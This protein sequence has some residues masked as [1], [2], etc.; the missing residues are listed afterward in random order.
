M[1]S[2]FYTKKSEK[3]HFVHLHILHNIIFSLHLQP[4]PFIFPVKNYTAL[5][6]ESFHL[7]IMAFSTDCYPPSTSIIF[8]VLCQHYKLVVIL[9]KPHN[10]KI[11]ELSSVYQLPI[12]FTD[13]L[14]SNHSYKWITLSV[15]QLQ[16]KLFLLALEVQM[17]SHMTSQYQNNF[18][19]TSREHTYV[20][21]PSNMM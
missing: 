20:C 2:V 8:K 5:L 17:R 3:S 11:T 21:Y 16:T 9:K 15:C 7:F 1:V 18:C 12:S 4:K 6:T 19:G 14:R 10:S 13:S